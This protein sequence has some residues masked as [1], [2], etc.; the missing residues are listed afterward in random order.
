MLLSL[1]NSYGKNTWYWIVHVSFSQN[2]YISFFILQGGVAESSSKRGAGA[3]VVLFPAPANCSENQLNPANITWFG[4]YF[5]EFRIIRK[6]VNF[7]LFDRMLYYKENEIK[8][9]CIILCTYNIVL[10]V[11][12]LFLKRCQKHSLPIILASGC[13]S[14]KL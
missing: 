5:I 13:V 9:F 10:I 7:L 8:T 3:E 14:T 6:I 1:L 4:E 12:L 11:Q 2:Q